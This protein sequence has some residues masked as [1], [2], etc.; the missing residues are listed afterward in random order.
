[1]KKGQITFG[2]YFHAVQNYL[3]AHVLEN[4][5]IKTY[6]TIILLVL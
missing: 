4:I 5:K 6:E 1:M 3:C 2:E